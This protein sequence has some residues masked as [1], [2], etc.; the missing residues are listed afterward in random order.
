MRKTTVGLELRALNGKE[1]TLGHKR[2]RTTMGHD[3][4]ALNG[5]QMNLGHK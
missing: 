5:M 2:E 1:I 4:K 3:V